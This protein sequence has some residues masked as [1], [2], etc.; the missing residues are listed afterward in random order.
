MTQILDNPG[1]F[2]MVTEQAVAQHSRRGF[3]GG[4]GKLG[5][6][7]LGL[8][9]GLGIA[10]QLGGAGRAAYASSLSC[11]SGCLGPCSSSTSQV[12]CGGYQCT[13]NC[14]GGF[15]GTFACAKADLTFSGS[16]CTPSCTN[17]GQQCS[18]GCS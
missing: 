5:L 17:Q 8:F 7:A 18:F 3:L 6:G 15:C 14:T 9:T 13:I 12:T 11:S 4:V 10:P 2:G 16:R 1:L